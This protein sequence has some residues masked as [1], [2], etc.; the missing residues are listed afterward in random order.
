MND[1][2]TQRLRRFFCIKTEGDTGKLVQ[3]VNG[4]ETKLVS[5]FVLLRKE[6]DVPLSGLT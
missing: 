5:D 3:V 6:H 2:I 4:L 1:R